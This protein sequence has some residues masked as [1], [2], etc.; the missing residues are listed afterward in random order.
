MDAQKVLA[1]KD[2]WVG[3]ETRPTLTFPTA[4]S[5][6]GKARRKL[7]AI[8]SPQISAAQNI[9]QIPHGLSN[10]SAPMV[11][12]INR[13]IACMEAILSSPVI[14]PSKYVP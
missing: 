1:A 8:P 5:A 4:T 13:A 10:G 14:R 9:A 2:L 7:G 6:F 11:S 12:C 3:P